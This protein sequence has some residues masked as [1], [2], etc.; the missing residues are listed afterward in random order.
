[1]KQRWW[2][3]VSVTALAGAS[4]AVGG[5]MRV[6]AGEGRSTVAAAAGVTR[7]PAGGG[8]AT[9]QQGADGKKETKQ[10]PPLDALKKIPTAYRIAATT[11]EL[12]AGIPCYC[13]CELYGHGGLLDCYRSQHAANCATCTEEA[14]LAG[15]L[16]EAQ[17]RRGEDNPVAVQT[18]VKNRYRQAVASQILQELPLGHLPN[19]RAYVNVCSDCHQPPQPAMHSAQEWDRSLARME[20][21]AQQSKRGIPADLWQAAVEYVKSVSARYSAEV[22]RKVREDLRTTVKRLQYDEGDSAYYP[23]FRNKVVDPASFD[24]MVAAYRTARELPTELLANTPSECGNCQEHGHSSLLGCL[25]S[26]HA[27]SCERTVEM[28]EELAAR[29]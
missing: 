6:I 10:F 20:A 21:Y 22:S 18:A 16:Y 5:T 1:M 3:L 24:R 14:L 2:V 27:V 19:A 25:N 28:V 17:R 4:L 9:L 13:P 15:Q 7:S 26:W 29:R 8:S 11:P 12:L 23:S